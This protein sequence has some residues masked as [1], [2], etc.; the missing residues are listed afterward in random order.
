MFCLSR[1]ITKSLIL[2]HRRVAQNKL[3]DIQQLTVVLPKKAY[4][5]GN[6]PTKFQGIKSPD[7]PTGRGG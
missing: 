3:S 7:P 5:S 6:K 1:R 4:N 2:I